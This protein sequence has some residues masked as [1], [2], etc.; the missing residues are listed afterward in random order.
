M[1]RA[2][3]RGR[4]EAVRPQSPGVDWPE[5]KPGQGLGVSRGVYGRAE[6]VDYGKKDMAP[7]GWE[8][9]R[10]GQGHGGGPTALPPAGGWG[11]WLAGEGLQRVPC[12]LGQPHSDCHIVEEFY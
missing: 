6:D 1:I 8:K 10:S 7:V 5:P 11:R 4:Q 3:H 9:H 12:S 2:A